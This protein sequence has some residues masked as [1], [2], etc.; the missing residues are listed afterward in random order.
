[1][2]RLNINC[3][4]TGGP[5]VILASGFRQPALSWN[6]V[7]ATVAHLSMLGTQ[8]GRPWNPALILFPG[9]GVS[10]LAFQLAIRRL[11]SDTIAG[12]LG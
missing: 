6:G 3:T 1:V 2:H 4:G 10:D 5:T 7:Q 9:V 8:S 12:D 11:I